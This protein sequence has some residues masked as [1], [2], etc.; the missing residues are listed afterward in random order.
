MNHIRTQNIFSK[1]NFI[2]PNLSI[3]SLQSYPSN[4]TKISNFLFNFILQNF[5]ST[6]LNIISSFIIILTV[7]PHPLSFHSQ[8][9]PSSPSSS[10]TLSPSLL[11]FTSHPSLSASFH[12]RWF[13]AR[14]ATTDDGGDK[15]ELFL[16]LLLVVWFAWV[17][18]GINSDFS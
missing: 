17:G 8:I 5:S 11:L 4:L 6:L 16:Y 2:Q 1:F 3:S 10:H 7:T 14:P 18:E 13:L 9:S 12:H 15:G